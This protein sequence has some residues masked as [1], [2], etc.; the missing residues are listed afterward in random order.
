LRFKDPAQAGT[1]DV[2]VADHE[3]FNHAGV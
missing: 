2:T 3:D 1:C